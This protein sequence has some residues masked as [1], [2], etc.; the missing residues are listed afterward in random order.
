MDAGKGPTYRFGPV[1]QPVVFSDELAKLLIDDLDAYVQIKFN[2]DKEG[3]ASSRPDLDE[4]ILLR[5]ATF[6]SFQV[7]TTLEFL[8]RVESRYWKC[9]ALRLEKDLQRKIVVPIPFLRSTE[10]HDTVYFNPSRINPKEDSVEMIK[11]LLIYAINSVYERHRSPRRRA[12]LIMNLSDWNMDEHFGLDQWLHIIDILQG[13]VLPI[14]VSQILLVNPPKDF[15]RT[16]KFIRFMCKDGFERRFHRVAEADL[17]KFLPDGYQE[18]LPDEFASGLASLDHLVHDFLVYRHTLERLS[19]PDSEQD[20][21]KRTNTTVTIKAPQLDE[22]PKAQN[23]R[24]LIHR[25]AFMSDLPP[26]P[27]ASSP[28]K[29]VDT[30]S[31]HTS[32]L[33]SESQVPA[34]SEL[35][36]SAETTP[37]A[38]RSKMF[39]KNNFEG[40][41]SARPLS[42]KK[43]QVFRKVASVPKLLASK[44][45]MRSSSK[46]EPSE[47][48]TKSEGFT[49][50]PR[51]RSRPILYRRG[52][53]LLRRLYGK[54]D[55]SETETEDHSE[56]IHECRKPR[57]LRRLSRREDGSECRTEDEDNSQ[58]FKICN[59]SNVDDL[60]VL[61]HSTLQRRRKIAFKSDGLSDLSKSSHTVTPC[62]TLFGRRSC[63]GT[64]LTSPIRRRRSGAVITRTAPSD[65]PLQ[66]ETQQ[67]LSLSRSSSEHATVSN[68]QR[69]LQR[70]KSKADL[71]AHEDVVLTSSSRVS[72]STISTGVA[73][74]STPPAR[75]RKLDF[76]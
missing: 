67:S 21:S 27:L 22:T 12:A 47:S 72:A 51:G 76:V 5:V 70:R 46:A 17:A 42:E 7:D 50:S 4:A 48:M 24:P 18:F 75:I 34:T 65:V 40:P 26:T 45:S 44:M 73:M 15:D 33:K 3:K 69:H 61:A 2:W 6:C 68:C 71:G 58:S 10:A 23:K 52:S 8:R 36:S 20:S 60:S 55:V 43:R 9:T 37:K 49:E 56:P 14:R 57:M 31:P 30:E 1:C 62:T 54:D 32:Y 29:K 19:S 66:E 35:S 41:Q 38:I 39:T 25:H 11:S 64:I 53:K 28:K 63:T 13:H 59:A 74:A 16:W